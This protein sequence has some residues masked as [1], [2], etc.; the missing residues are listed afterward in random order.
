MRYIFSYNR[1]FHCC[2]WINPLWMS[3][4]RYF[5]FFFT[6][7]SIPKNYIQSACIYMYIS[8]YINMDAYAIDSKWDRYMNWLLKYKIHILCIL[9]LILCVLILSRCRFV[10]YLNSRW[11]NFLMLLNCF[12][13]TSVTT[14][15]TVSGN[16]FLIFNQK[17][18]KYLLWMKQATRHIMRL[19]NYNISL[20]VW[21]K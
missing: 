5:I 2:S 4:L 8:S 15:S 17:C 20:I 12:P 14:K 16:K 13:C 18:L 6:E 3:I 9:I 19:T 21:F 10:K 1:A 7:H 11:N